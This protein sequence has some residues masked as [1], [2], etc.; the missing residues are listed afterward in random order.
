MTKFS[1][2]SP[3]TLYDKMDILSRDLLFYLSDDLVRNKLM[4]R[5]GE[6]D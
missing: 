6:W 3:S 2:I 5:V 4:I 1:I